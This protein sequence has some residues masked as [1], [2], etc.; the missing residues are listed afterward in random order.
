MGD[1]SIF[2]LISPKLH[3]LET[4]NLQKQQFKGSKVIVGN[5]GLNSNGFVHNIVDFV[6]EGHIYVS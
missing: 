4:S 3:W 6:V 1:S 2:L 5:G